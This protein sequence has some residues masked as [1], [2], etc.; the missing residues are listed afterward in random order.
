MHTQ[1]RIY[2]IG[3]SNENDIVIDHLTVSIFHA[4]IFEDPENNI[5]YTDL[6]SKHG[7]FVNGKR[8]LEP[9]LLQ[10]ED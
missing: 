7:S 3:S 5:F 6:Q 9:I 1:S 10:V 8:I 2:K 4:E